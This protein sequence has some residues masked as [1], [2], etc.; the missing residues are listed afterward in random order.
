MQRT[1]STDTERAQVAVDGVAEKYYGLQVIDTMQKRQLI[2]AFGYMDIT[3]W[4]MSARLHSGIVTYTTDETSMLAWNYILPH[5]T[6]D[7]IVI[8][9]NKYLTYFSANWTASILNGST[10]SMTPLQRAEYIKGITLPTLVNYAVDQFPQYKDVK[11]VILDALNVFSLT[12]WHETTLV[13][14]FI[15][16][17]VASYAKN[18]Y[19]ISVPRWF[20][21]EVTKLGPQ[22]TH[23]QISALSWKIV[24]THNVGTLPLTLPEWVLG[25]FIDK[26]NTTM[27]AVVGFSGD[28]ADL[29]VQAN[30]VALR[31][32]FKDMIGSRPQWSGYKTYVTGLAGIDYDL[33]S[34]A[35]AD[36]RLIEPF[37]ALLVIVFIALFFRSGV[38][39]WVPLLVVGMAYIMANAAMY[40]IGLYIGGI[41]Y[42]IRLVTFT[43]I[44][45]AGSDYCIFIVSRFR[46]ER[47]LGKKKNEA[48]RIAV[49]WAG[50]SIATSGATVMVAFLA[51]AIFTFPLVK[52]MGLCLAVSIGITL[53][54]ALTMIPALLYLIGDY[55][56]WPT[57][58]ARWKKY[59]KAVRD[60][61]RLHQGYFYRAAQVSVKY[62][63]PI[64]AICLLV[65]IP[66]T[67]LVYTIEPSYDFL[68]SMANAE[69]KQGVDAMTSGFGAG[70]IL[71][72]Y[73]VVKYNSQLLDNKTKTFNSDKIN[74]TDALAKKLSELGSV[75][76][77]TSSTY[78]TLTGLRIDKETYWTAPEVRLSL[79]THNST[80][81]LTVVLAHQPFDSKSVHA[82]GDIRKL[83]SDFKANNPIMKDANIYVGGST[84][85]T[86]DI[87][88]TISHDFPISAALVLLGVYLILL[89]VLGSVLIPFRL[90]LTILLSISW[91]LAIALI[92]FLWLLSIP[93]L[94]IMPLLLFV[95]LMGLGMD[96]DIFLMT[97]IKEA[98][99]EGKSDE[100][101]IAYAVQH[102]GSIISICGIIMAGA[103]GTMML[104]TTGMLKEFGFGL[105]FA[106]LLDAT[107]VRIYLVP[108][109][110]VLLKK[111][112]WWAPFGLQKVRRK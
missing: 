63:G 13:H 101:A 97:R 71:P 80:V 48:M 30:I 24:E 96:Y 51:L 37:T 9:E 40:L 6:N 34:T 42:T 55:V 98:V 64:V 46:E 12:N 7:T 81:R 109:V 5:I 94:W 72:T 44:M 11:P 26:K 61:K 23:E 20:L 59:R 25:T 91:T 103:F 10:T 8:A 31:G 86:A 112:N 65:S 50:E 77:V 39:P 56:F 14:N 27:L 35:E 21:E 70:N 54:M 73:V 18:L 76:K 52:V 99:M 108:A 82:I 85:G 3:N 43:M 104:S 92:V 22:P 47:I 4:N 69:A 29:K 111:W 106:I 74:A 33:R 87:S 45:G 16:D 15:Y 28:P 93:V 32:D 62:A 19:N 84:A 66:T 36:A 1:F 17:S 95:I 2:S 60:K 107:L 78:S 75:Y 53:L 90:M 67:Y 89:F 79:G 58:G 68:S 110:M 57:M 102:T 105:C 88:V 38:A 41:H 49:V 83:C 100:K